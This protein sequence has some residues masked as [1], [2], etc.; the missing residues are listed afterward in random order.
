MS[1]T[2]AEASSI[3]ASVD[4]TVRRSAV[5]F[6][7]GLY[8]ASIVG[9]LTISAILVSVTGGSWR[10]V[11]TALLDGSIRSAG[12]WGLTLDALAPLLVVAVGTVITTKAGLTNIGQEGQLLIGAGC[13]AFIA[14]K[15]GG[16]GGVT[17]IVALIAAMFGGALWAGIAAVLRYWRG[18]PEVISTLL[19]VFIANQVINIG[20]KYR[21]L[22][23]D[24]DRTNGNQNNVGTLLG[25][26]RRLPHLSLFG[27]Q[28]SIGVLLALLVAV[29]VA[30]AL[31]RTV[32]GFRLRMLGMNPRA[33]QRAGVPA[34]L[35][36]ATALMLCGA[37]AGLAGGMLLTSGPGYR[38][39]T[40][41]S[42]SF[43]WDGLLVALV[44]RDR[45][46]LAI[47]AAFA[48]AC[49]RTG[50]GFLSSAGVAGDIVDVVKALLVLAL[51]LPP[52][53]LF[54]R[55]RRRAQRRASEAT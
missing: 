18:I 7:L 2:I 24:T 55:D 36:G 13:A 45:P 15:L 29:L 44:A 39:T 54:V 46:L 12:A 34:V 43:G 19:L 27:N 47:P 50:S 10:A 9:A 28:F 22:L 41:F 38:I 52:A 51:L 32:F 21:G 14:T 42:R 3:D 17:V 5:V 33:A 23:L 40:G 30:T 8:T 11:F 53:V 48:F 25:P 1:T 31:A 6:T 4:R 26:A 37:F 49:L 16:P 20:L 35:A